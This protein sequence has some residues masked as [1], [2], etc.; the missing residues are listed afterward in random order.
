MTDAQIEKVLGEGCPVAAVL[1]ARGG[2][3]KADTVQLSQAFAA[4]PDHPKGYQ[5]A[6]WKVELFGPDGDAP[7]HAVF[8]EAESVVGV[9]LVRTKQSHE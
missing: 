2:W 9:S 8:V 5:P 3:L 7:W 1:L 6:V 4:E